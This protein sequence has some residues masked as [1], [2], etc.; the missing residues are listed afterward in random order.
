MDDLE[1]FR[2]RDEIFYLVKGLSGAHI[3]ER[4]R[5]EKQLR[6]E[7]I[8]LEIDA[9]DING[10]GLT[11]SAQGVQISNS[12]ASKVLKKYKEERPLRIAR[13]HEKLAK[14]KDQ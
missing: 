1:K 6:I 5:L 14:L 9:D 4:E 13:Y 10:A 2:K 8:A 3:N 12:V 11:F 7:E